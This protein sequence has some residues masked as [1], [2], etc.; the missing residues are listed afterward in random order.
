MS[1]VSKEK[2][3]KIKDRVIKD[4]KAIP[5]SAQDYAKLSKEDREALVEVLTENDI[6]AEKYDEHMRKMWPKPVIHKVKSW[7]YRG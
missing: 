3:D 5:L 4:K 2:K 6:D 7:R 1:G